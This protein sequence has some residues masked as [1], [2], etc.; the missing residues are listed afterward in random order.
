MK[1]IIG[2]LLMMLLISTALTTI[3]VNE[4]NYN[5]CE[6]K[7][8]KPTDVPDEWLEGADQYQTET[9]NYGMPIS[10]GF[11]AAQE[12]KP[13]KEDLTAVALYFFDLNAPSDIDILVSIRESLNGINLTSF[14]INADDKRIKRGGSWVMF[15]FDD[16]TVTPEE[17]YYIVCYANGGSLNNSYCWFFD[18]SNK[19]DR[20]IVW[21]SIN[22][23]KNWSDLENPDWGPEFV[24]LDSCFI[25]YFQ[26]PPDRIS[27]NYHNPFLLRL[28]ERFLLLKLL[29]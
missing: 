14:R 1:K 6:L 19:Y 21:Q 3:A 11:R 23:G 7:S 20:G 13:T 17:T 25:T 26:E 5:F 28:I 18:V 12:F 2:I 4:K 10:K 8:F 16:I 27:F 15:D 29:L 24:E 22:G 9:I